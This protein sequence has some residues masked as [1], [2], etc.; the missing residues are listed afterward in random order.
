MSGRFG[1]DAGDRTHQR[2]A[3]NLELRALSDGREQT[4]E[5]RAWAQVAVAA[6][7]C[8][9]DL[10]SVG[11]ALHAGLHAHLPQETLLR[12]EFVE[13]RSRRAGAC[14]ESGLQRFGSGCGAHDA[15]HQST[16]YA[17]GCAQG[18]SQERTPC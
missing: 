15:R 12:H 17:G 14:V 1:V 2:A 7:K 8:G 4:A 16:R 13:D 5:A 11:D 6:K 3:E 18:A 10:A 9:D